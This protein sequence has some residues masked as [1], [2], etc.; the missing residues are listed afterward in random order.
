MVHQLD[1]VKVSQSDEM[2]SKSEKEEQ[3]KIIK[4][5]RNKWAYFF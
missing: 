4:S 1:V 3:T 2:P 5:L